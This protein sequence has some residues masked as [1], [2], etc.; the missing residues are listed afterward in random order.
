LSD[1]QV[2]IV[3]G[4][5]AA[6]CCALR[7]TSEGIRCRIYEAGS[8]L[9]GRVRTDEV[10]GFLLDRGFQVLLTA[11]PEAKQVLDY[12]ALDLKTFEPGALIRYQGKFHRFTDPW[13]RPQHLLSTAFSPVASFA[14][15]LR[16]AKLRRRVCRGTLEELYARP[17]TTTI[18]LL[19]REGFS[20]RIIECFFRPFLGGVFL[21]GD[22]QT[23]SRMFEFV[24]RMFSLGSAAVP[25]VGMGEIVKQIAAKLP[26]E[27]IHLNAP[28]EKVDSDSLVLC[29]GESVTG[30]RM[31]AACDAPAANRLG[32]NETTSTGKGV[33]CFYFAASRPPIKE[34]ILVLNG[35]NHGPINNL[36]VPSQVSPQYA[37]AGQA[38]VS[39]SVLGS[40]SGGPHDTN[41]LESQVRQQ[42]CEWF[43]ED[44]RE[45][46][47]LRIYQIPYALPD[48]APPALSPVAK[49]SLRS[50]GIFVGGDYLDTASIQGA[51]ISGRRA[52]EQIIDSRTS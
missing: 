40:L 31:V 7:L 2:N 5:L 8:S 22:L 30:D 6:L 11:Y 29:S 1:L 36:C 15:K 25:A 51:M 45:W 49:G 32:V 21:E 24:F 34:P 27:S 41:D 33:T 18:D 9:G 23:S 3:G 39:V 46:R 28:V 52:A 35:D 50:D 43:G 17:E 12:D 16:I 20:S 48:Q 42:L 13:R 37:P 38:L 4:G 26:N 19:Q 44:V 14:D 10:E 47:T